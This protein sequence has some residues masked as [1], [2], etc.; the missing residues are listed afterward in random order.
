LDRRGFWEDVL[1]IPRTVWWAEAHAAEVAEQRAADPQHWTVRRLA[2]RFGV[3][4]PTIRKALRLAAGQ[5]GR[6]L[7][8]KP[9]TRE[10]SETALVKR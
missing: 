1:E 6:S 2:E 4:A 8:P 9:P 5:A 10:A 7:E 3:T